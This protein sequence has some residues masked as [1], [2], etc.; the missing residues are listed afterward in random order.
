MYKVARRASCLGM[1]GIIFYGILGALLAPVS[2]AYAEG[3]LCA[4]V[5]EFFSSDV[6]RAC[7]NASVELR[8]EFRKRC[9]KSP[10]KPDCAALKISAA[11]GFALS[12]GCSRKLGSWD[13]GF[14]KFA[15]SSCAEVT[16]KK[17]NPAAA[18]KFF[19]DTISRSPSPAPNS[20]FIIQSRYV[21]KSG[22]FAAFDWNSLSWV[23]QGSSQSEPSAVA[24]V[25][26]V[27]PIR[28]LGNSVTL[29]DFPEFKKYCEREV[30]PSIGHGLHP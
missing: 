28:E 7:C 14:N 6:C 23:V 3:D 8:D 25:S 2:A 9:E 15:I 19:Q 12:F 1:R 10:E 27:E 16:K 20:R 17:M 29:D 5:Y 22:G 26:E 21:N 18:A 11:Q 30:M 4:D 13:P 24:I